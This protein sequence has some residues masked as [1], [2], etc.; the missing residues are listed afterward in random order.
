[1]QGS[2]DSSRICDKC[3]ANL[4]EAYEFRNL[5]INS[6]H[7]IRRITL[8]EEEKCWNKKLISLQSEYQ[9]EEHLLEEM[10]ESSIKFEPNQFTSFIEEEEDD[11]EFQEIEESPRKSKTKIVRKQK[12]QKSSNVKR[13]PCNICGKLLSRGAMWMHKKN[14][15]KDM[16][17]SLEC[18]LCFKL[19]DSYNALESHLTKKHD[20]EVEH[21]C[22][23]R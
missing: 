6:D 21:T 13:R 22:D 7:E 20:D 11:E 17:E 19:F 23:V 1:M 15:H 18:H 3:L 5:C 2:I 4:D 12:A 8:E 16:S 10:N 14:L 9:G